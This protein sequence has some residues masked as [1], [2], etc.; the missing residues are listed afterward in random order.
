MSNFPF[1]VAVLRLV[2]LMFKWLYGPILISKADRLGTYA[3][4][5]AYCFVLSLVPFLA[6]T[7]AVGMQISTEL[8]LNKHYAEH[9]AEVLGDIIPMEN[10]TRRSEFLRRWSIPPRA[11]W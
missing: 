2:L 4:A 11:G 7:F 3:A 5:L 10:P 8:D 6:V 9:Y 1:Y